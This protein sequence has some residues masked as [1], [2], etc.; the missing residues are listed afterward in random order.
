M[1]QRNPRFAEISWISDVGQFRLRNWIERKQITLDASTTEGVHRRFTL[2]DA[3]KIAFVAL[4][5]QYGMTVELAN[6]ETDELLKEPRYVRARGVNVATEKDFRKIVEAFKREMWVWHT[7]ED[8]GTQWMRFRFD[9]EKPQ[10]GVII[11]AGAVVRT[12]VEK[13]EKIT[14]QQE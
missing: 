4:L 11:D 10:T 9:K 2:Y 1:E 7:T 5:T 3:L 14:S 13:W 6:E 8:N 12:V